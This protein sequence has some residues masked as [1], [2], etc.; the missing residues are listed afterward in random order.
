MILRRVHRS[1]KVCVLCPTA[2]CELVS[3]DRQNSTEYLSIILFFYTFLCLYHDT[4]II[5][6]INAIRNS[7]N[8][9]DRTQVSTA[10]LCGDWETYQWHKSGRSV[11]AGCLA[12]RRTSEES[13]TDEDTFLCY[14]PLSA[15]QIVFQLRPYAPSPL[16]I[17]PAEDSAVTMRQKVTQTWM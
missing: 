16:S 13:D 3:C 9:D 1:A 15:G 14:S 5:N 8:T 4:S 11:P 2:R 17:P 7:S 10:S 6:F 12:A